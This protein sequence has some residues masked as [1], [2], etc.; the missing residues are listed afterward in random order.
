MVLVV[1]GANVDH[2]LDRRGSINSVFEDV[3]GLGFADTETFGDSAWPV[4]VR[5]VTILS[6]VGMVRGGDEAGG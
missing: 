3:V 1:A 2:V 6:P 5:K 4:A